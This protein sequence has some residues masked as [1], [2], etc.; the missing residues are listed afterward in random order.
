MTV[1]QLPETQ[2]WHNENCS[3][4]LRF[5]LPWHCSFALLRSLQTLMV[6]C[7]SRGHQIQVQYE[8]L[9]IYICDN[10][11]PIW[12]DA[13]Y[14][15]LLWAKDAFWIEIKFTY[16]HFSLVD[17]NLVMAGVIFLVYNVKILASLYWFCFLPS[18][19]AFGRVF[20]NW[21][22]VGCKTD[23]PVD[24][25]YFWSKPSS[26]IRSTTVCLICKF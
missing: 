21:Q 19:I 16:K 8:E 22:V 5:K 4:L 2:S 11:A 17:N 12:L 6:C 23:L 9:H 18:I 25:I 14:E 1:H 15:V 26:Q 20:D 24:E 3:Q 13:V 10:F 7:A